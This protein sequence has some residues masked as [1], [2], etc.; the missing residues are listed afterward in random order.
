MSDTYNIEINTLDGKSIDLGE[1]NI[2][3]TDLKDIKNKLEQIHGYDKDGISFTYIFK[4]ENTVSID[5]FISE[6]ISHHKEFGNQYID[7]LKIREVIDHLELYGTPEDSHIFTELGAKKY[8]EQKQFLELINYYSF[9][10]EHM[11]LIHLNSI[12][13]YLS[14]L[15]LTI[16]AVII[17]LKMCLSENKEKT[18]NFF[19]IAEPTILGISIITSLIDLYLINKPEQ[20]LDKAHKLQTIVNLEPRTQFFYNQNTKT[21]MDIMKTN[22]PCIRRRNNP[23]SSFSKYDYAR[24]LSMEIFVD[25]RRKTIIEKKEENTKNLIEQN[26]SNNELEE[27]LL[28]ISTL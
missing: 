3:K 4:K 18:K 10:P 19:L 20:F 14:Q 15:L 2:Y 13:C 27:S 25:I 1:F 6:E 17:P 5:A 8:S 21:F 24:L 9:K 26:H 23:P 11:Y 28:E 22:E 12:I 16:S 7:N